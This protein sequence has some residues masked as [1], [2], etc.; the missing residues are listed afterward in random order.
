MA[1]VFVFVSIELPQIV[2]Q[3]VGQV[4]FPAVAALIS[5]QAIAQRLVGNALQVDIQRGVNTQATL[6]NRFG[7][8]RCFQVLSNLFEKIRR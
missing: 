1:P 2:A 3:D 6:V 5:V 7:S 8:V 4:P